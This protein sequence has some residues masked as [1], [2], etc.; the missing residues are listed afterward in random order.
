VVLMFIGVKML[1]S[2]FVH[3]PIALSLGVVATVLGGSVIASILLPAKEEPAAEAGEGAL[4]APVAEL[5][6][7]PVVERID[8]PGV[9]RRSGR[10]A[11]ETRE[12]EKE[13]ELV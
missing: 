9:R 5:S 6:P 10:A 12:E 2:E 3:I 11:E 4:G 7:E 13:H 8:E 1:I